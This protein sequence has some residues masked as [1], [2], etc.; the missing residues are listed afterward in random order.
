[1]S[2]QTEGQAAQKGGGMVSMGDRFI[3]G[4]TGPQPVVHTVE[5]ILPGTIVCRSCQGGICWRTEWKPE[6]VQD[7][8]LSQRNP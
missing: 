8:L 5:E 1:M 3:T 6:E 2:W 4:R 7:L